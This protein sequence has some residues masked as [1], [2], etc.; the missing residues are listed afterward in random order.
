M[1]SVQHIVNVK[2]GGVL[3]KLWCKQPCKQLSM[4]IMQSPCCGQDR[5]RYANNSNNSLFSCWPMMACTVATQFQQFPARCHRAYVFCLTC[6]GS[7][8]A[9]QL[10]H[11]ATKFARIK[12][13]CIPQLAVWPT[14]QHAAEGSPLFCK[15][16]DWSTND[17]SFSVTVAMPLWISTR[18]QWRQHSIQLNRHYCV[19]PT[20]PSWQTSSA[21]CL[22]VCYAAL[23]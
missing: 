7:S 5:R 13:N 19:S 18:K 3:Q 6:T 14:P 21:L 15:C 11:M 4:S 23:W 20:T 2:D 12:V 10:V 22:A 1:T 16:K 17:S 9:Y 8:W